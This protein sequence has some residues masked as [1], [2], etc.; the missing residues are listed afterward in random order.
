M[1][2]IADAQLIPHREE[3]LVHTMQALGDNTRYKLFKLLMSDERLCVSELA[4]RLGVSTPAISQHFKTFEL[5]G[6]VE[7]EREGQKIC[8]LLKQ[9][10]KFVRKIIEIIGGS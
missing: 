1:A 7:K 8:Y 5:V 10:D 4:E 3:R 6:L 2:R 9:N